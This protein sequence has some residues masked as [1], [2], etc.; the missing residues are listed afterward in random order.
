[1]AVFNFLFQL[2]PQGENVPDGFPFP[3]YFL[4]VSGV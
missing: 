2:V 4:R 1:M 3:G